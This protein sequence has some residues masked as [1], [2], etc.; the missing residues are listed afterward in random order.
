MAFPD[1]LDPATYIS[2]IRTVLGFDTDNAT[3][4]PQAL[5]DQFAP[6]AEATIKKRV[7][8]YATLEND[9][10]LFLRMATLAAVGAA[11]CEPLR[12][13]MPEKEKSPFFDYTSSVN[14]AVKEITLKNDVEVNL[15]Q[16][17]TFTRATLNLF[18]LAGPQR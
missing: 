2:Q 9:D 18:T 7:P 15:A 6:V 12:Q 5:I 14:W 17:S 4:V 1:I 8:N 3:D 10:L 16:I 13:R 11:L